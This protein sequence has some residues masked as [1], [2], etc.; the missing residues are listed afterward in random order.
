MK[1]SV[2]CVLGILFL[3]ITAPFGA[4]AAEITSP[5]LI[6]PGSSWY[7]WTALYIGGNVGGGWGNTSFNGTDFGRFGTSTFS[8]STNSSGWLGGGQI[9]G[10]F[11]F[12]QQ[13]VIGIEADGDGAKI[14][15]SSTGC[16][17][18]ATGLARGCGTDSEQLKDF[19][20]ARGR[21][22]YAFGNL[23]LYGTGGW[24]WGNSSGSH[25]TTCVS[26]L[27]ALCPG[28]STAFAGGA[29]SFSKSLSGWTA[30]AGLEWG[31]L[32]NW[33]VR[34]EYLHVEFDNVSTGF[35]T[36]ITTGRVTT[37][38]TTSVAS[39]NGFDMVRIGLNFLFR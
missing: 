23:L 37:P 19:G 1:C 36:T 25:A 28:A 4:N 27:I 30:G 20:T 31:F 9:G 18:L 13:W 3:L 15:S 22:G 5:A 8:G 34:V 39:N 10:N 7:N 35:S 21:F 12:A 2:R 29:A 32:R 11:E 14:S 26:S 17:T 38:I 33:T 24:A 16:S 6:P